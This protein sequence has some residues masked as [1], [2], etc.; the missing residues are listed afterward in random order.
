MLWHQN[1]HGTHP[2]ACPETDVS[3]TAQTLAHQY[4]LAQGHEQGRHFNQVGHRLARQGALMTAADRIKHKRDLT[5]QPDSKSKFEKL[6]KEISDSGSLNQRNKQDLSIT[7]NDT[8]ETTDS[9]TEGSLNHILKERNSGLFQMSFTFPLKVFSDGC[10]VKLEHGLLKIDVPKM[11]LQE[12]Q[13]DQ[14]T[15]NDT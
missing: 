7:E 4:G 3:E 5:A 6:L 11:V 13:E 9:V 15:L 12:K 14:L 10:R 2:Q 8:N 1:A